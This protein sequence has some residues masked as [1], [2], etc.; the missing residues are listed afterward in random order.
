MIYVYILNCGNSYFRCDR[1]PNFNQLED[2][3][4]EDQKIFVELLLFGPLFLRALHLYPF[5]PCLTLEGALNPTHQEKG[6]AFL[7]CLRS[8]SN[9]ATFSDFLEFIDCLC[10]YSFFRAVIWKRRDPEGANA[11]VDAAKTSVHIW[12]FIWVFPCNI[13]IGFCMKKSISDSVNLWC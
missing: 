12:L 10:C 3:G 9:L 2:L 8:K 4:L 11:Y 13:A 1:K 7:P 5:S 6:I